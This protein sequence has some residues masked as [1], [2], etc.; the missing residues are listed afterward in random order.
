LKVVINGETFDY[1]QDRRPMSEALAIEK[2]CGRRYAEWESELFGGSAWAMAVLAWLI[3]RRE[4][5]EVPLADILDGTVDFDYMEYEVSI[6]R[7]SAEAKAAREAEAKAAAGNP[8]SGADPA[9]DGTP[10]TPAATKPSSRKSS[11]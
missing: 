11:T 4:G 3:W 2:E 10:T 5:R 6:L 8:T 9:P 7:A 1:D